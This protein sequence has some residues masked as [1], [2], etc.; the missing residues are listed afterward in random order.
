MG[1]IAAESAKDIVESEL[2]SISNQ[3]S[4]IIE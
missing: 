1:T 3:I 4:Q 2:Y